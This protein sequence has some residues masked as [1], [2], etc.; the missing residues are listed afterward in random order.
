MKDLNTASPL[1]MHIDLN[2]C[3]ATVEQQARPSL[4]G[5]PLAVTNRLVARSCVIACSHEAKTRGVKVGMRYDLAK[6][7]IPDLLMI[8]TDPPKYHYVYQKLVAIMKSYS[9]KITMKSID[10]GVIDFHEA[11]EQPSLARMIEIGYEIKQRLKDEVGSYMTCNVGI[12]PNRFLAKLAAG[13]NKPDGL[14]VITHHNL[15]AVLGRLELIDLPGIA[16]RFE[17]RL[18]YQGITTPLK[19]LDADIFTLHRLVFKSINGNYWHQRLRGFEPDDVE[20]KLG[21]VGRQYVLDIK[22]NDDDI[23]LPRLHH[24]CHS[25]GMKLRYNAVDAR[26]ISIWVR[27]TDGSFFKKRQMYD[28]TFFTDHDIYRR[29]RELFSDRPR[30]GRVGTIGITCYQLT[31]TARQQASLFER[32]DAHGRLISAMDDINETYG[33]F[34]ITYAHALAGK[35]V[36]KQKLPFG[37]VKYFELLCQAPQLQLSAV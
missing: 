5:K 7:I 6:E 17:K 16:H 31:P 19:F 30:R 28:H 14:D 26:G 22:T 15:C 24:L 37:S 2:S 9:A 10:E 3:F 4:R 20:T 1:I 34:C 13:L 32:F 23:L 29:A 12:A 21:I 27:Y 35:K 33:N 25:T 18:R 11:V 8:E 36:I